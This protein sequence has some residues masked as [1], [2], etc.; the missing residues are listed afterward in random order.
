MNFRRMKTNFPAPKTKVRGIVPGKILEFCIAESF[1]TF[2][3]NENKLS[4][5]LK[6]GSGVMSPENLCVRESFNTFAV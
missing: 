1:G 4:F 2:S 6:R 3:E 5:P